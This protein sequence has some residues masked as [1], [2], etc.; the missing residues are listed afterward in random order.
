MKHP[1]DNKTIL[2]ICL[3]ALIC[4]CALASGSESKNFVLGWV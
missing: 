4:L 1:L 3:I 2:L